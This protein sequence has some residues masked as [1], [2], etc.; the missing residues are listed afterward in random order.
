MPARKDGKK[1]IKFSKELGN[2]ICEN[3]EKGMTLT[4][5]CHKFKDKV[6]PHNTIMKWR[7]EKDDF[8][9]QYTT[10]CESRMYK[11]VDEMYDLADAPPPEHEDKIKINAE[12][13]SRRLKI[14]TMKF[15]ASKLAPKLFGDKVQVENVGEPIIQIMNYSTPGE[16]S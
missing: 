8:K 7:R 2:F 11:W 14:D 15:L 3:I 10:A 5:I 13:Q 4:E 1:Y 6:P 9:E 16:D 12:L